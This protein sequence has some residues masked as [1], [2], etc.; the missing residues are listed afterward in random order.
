MLRTSVTLV[1]KDHLR[2]KHERGL[3]RQVVFMNGL[4]RVTLRTSVTLVYKDYTRGKHERGLCRQVVFINGFKRIESQVHI[5]ATI[6]IVSNWTGGRKNVCGCI[7]TKILICKTDGRT[8]DLINAAPRRNISNKE[9]QEMSILCRF[10]T[11]VV[12]YVLDWS[13]C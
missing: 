8:Q 13:P 10:K 9:I 3:C 1:Y 7:Y 6:T 2:G 5:S 4:P 11:C 12:P